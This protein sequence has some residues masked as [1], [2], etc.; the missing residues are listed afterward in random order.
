MPWRRECFATVDMT[1]EVDKVI[2]KQRHRTTRSG[3]TY[4]PAETVRM[5]RHIRA[6]FEKEHG[7]RFAKHDGP[8]EMT[9][10]S[11][12]ELAKSN[13]KFWAGR[14]DLGKPDEDNVL[15]LS[16][17]AL[18]GL[19]YVDDSQVVNGRE[20]KMPRTSYGSGNKI[21]IVLNYYKE[22]YYK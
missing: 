22:A 3:H 8:V 19:A 18:N 7:L 2:G 15:K 13:P 16:Q 1:I 4:T 17:D 12:R 6:R 9:V 21:R 10:F 11:T 5:E 14:S 20:V